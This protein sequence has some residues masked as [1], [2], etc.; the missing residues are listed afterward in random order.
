MA[1]KPSRIASTV[2]MGL[3]MRVAIMNPDP[4]LSSYLGKARDCLAFHERIVAAPVSTADIS[5]DHPVQGKTVFQGGQMV[6]KSKLRRLVKR[7]AYWFAFVAR[8]SGH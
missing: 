7:R 6:K 5:L 8:L 4:S 2:P 3:K 1:N